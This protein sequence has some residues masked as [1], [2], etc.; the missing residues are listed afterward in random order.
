MGMNRTNALSLALPI[1]TL[2]D[3]LSLSGGPSAEPASVARECI[4]VGEDRFVRHFVGGLI[5][6]FAFELAI[7]PARE[8]AQQFRHRILGVGGHFLIGRTVPL[9]RDRHA[10]FMAAAPA[11]IDVGAKLIEV[12]ALDRLQGIGDAMQLA[13]LRRMRPDRFGRA[14]CEAIGAL[15]RRAV[16]LRC[17]AR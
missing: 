14:C 8:I 10:V 11:L 12:A 1:Q 5:L 16:A 3:P 9:D 13:I 6:I 7:E 4:F 17:E 2:P 15:E